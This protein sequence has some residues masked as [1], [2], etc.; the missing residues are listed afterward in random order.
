MANKKIPKTLAGVKVPKPLRRGLRDLAASQTGRQALS[1][2]LEAACAALCAAQAAPPAKAAKAG[3]AQ[4][5]GAAAPAPPSK[6]EARAAT[7]AAMEDAAHAFT[8]TL[9]RKAPAQAEPPSAA[10][11]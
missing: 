7:A 4:A 5:A 9:K 3:K 8:D 10:T 6:D 1:E 2:A 11:H